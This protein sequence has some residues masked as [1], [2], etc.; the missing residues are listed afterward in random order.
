MGAN[1]KYRFQLYGRKIGSLINRFKQTIDQR[2]ENFGAQ[3]IAFGIF[4]ILNYPIYY[5]IWKFGSYQSYEN[6]GLRI[7]CTLLC[8]GLLLKRYW[9]KKLLS[10]F[11]VYWLFT[12]GFCLPFFFFFMMLKNNGATVWL[13]SANTIV[14]WVLLLVDW[15][16]YICIFSL[17]IVFA[18]AAYYFTTPLPMVPTS[19]TWGVVAQFLGS[20]IVVA[21]FA[22]NKQRFDTEKLNSMRSLSRSIAHELRTPLGALENSFVG[23]RRYLPILIK[24]YHTAHEAKLIKEEIRPDHIETLKNI[25]DES[26]LEIQYSHMVID[27][28]LSNVNQ[29]KV[30]Q[31]LE[32]HS[33]SHCIENALARYPFT[34]E[35]HKKIVHWN[36]HP[37]F[38]FKGEEILF[39]H[40]LFNLLKNALYFIDKAQKGEIKIWLEKGSEYNY[41]HFQDTGTGISEDNLKRLFTRFHSTERHGSGLGLAFCKNVMQNLGGDIK[42]YSQEGTFTEFVLNFPALRNRDI[43]SEQ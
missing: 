28:M 31:K 36:R 33:I 42:C 2:V 22:R 8:A 23:I 39:I 7:T 1:F 20:F 43:R 29:A 37:D 10:W 35:H 15:L 40:V 16:S 5:L 19:Y 11:S 14:F 27:T 9:P 24:S 26:Q 32:R 30:P 12:L 4:G 6:L 34:N 41:L 38:Y 3:Y 21:F 25:L 18:F 13:M 17:G